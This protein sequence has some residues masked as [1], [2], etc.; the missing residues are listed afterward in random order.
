MN[1]SGRRKLRGKKPQRGRDV[2]SR[3]LESG[4]GLERRCD[5][6]RLTRGD[7][8]TQGLFSAHEVLHSYW[9]I[10]SA[11]QERLYYKMS[12]GWIVAL[13]ISISF[14]W[15]KDALSLQ[16]CITGKRTCTQNCHYNHYSTSSPDS[17][18]VTAMWG[19][20]G[21]WLTVGTVSNALRTRSVI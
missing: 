9:S 11:A 13:A 16:H 19:W 3:T 7:A 20:G 10:L 6:L 12:S 8:S 1:Y 17:C 21:E 18:E 4:L 2:V 15:N 5:D 14:P